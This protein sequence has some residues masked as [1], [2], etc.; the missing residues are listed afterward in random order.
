M[1]NE[2]LHARKDVVEA[3]KKEKAEEKTD[4]LGRNIPQPQSSNTPPIITLM[5]ASGKET[6]TYLDTTVTKIGSSPFKIV[7]GNGCDATMVTTSCIQKLVLSP[8]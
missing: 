8:K 3:F 7:L 2:N 1:H 6:H 4:L 5:L